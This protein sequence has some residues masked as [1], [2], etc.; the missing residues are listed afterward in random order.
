[1]KKWAKI[2]IIVASA[3]S[4]LAI[5]IIVLCCQ[6]IIKKLNETKTYDFGS[7]TITLPAKFTKSEATGDWDW[8]LNELNSG[9]SGGRE[10]KSDLDL[11]GLNIDS[12]DEYIDAWM[13][14]DTTVQLSGP[15]QSDGLTYLEYSISF[16]GVYFSCATFFYET[17]SAYHYI[18]FWCKTD[19]YENYKPKFIDWANT[20]EFK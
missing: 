7:Y 15:Y 19:D 17:S 12:L 1:M 2:S 16:D 6:F 8:T 18:S 11:Y 13:E 20:V 9:V 4:V 5:T 3:F 14:D 10:I